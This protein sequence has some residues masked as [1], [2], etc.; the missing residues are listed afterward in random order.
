LFY[1]ASASSLGSLRSSADLEEAG[2]ELIAAAMIFAGSAVQTN[3]F[4]GV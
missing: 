2:V 4:G 1:R 3:R